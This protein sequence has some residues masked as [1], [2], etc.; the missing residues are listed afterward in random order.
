MSIKTISAAQQKRAVQCFPFFSSIAMLVPVLIPIWIAASIFV[1]AAV[2]SH[3]NP[4]VYEYTRH[5]GYRFYS[6]VGALVVI[7]NFSSHLASMAGGAIR[8]ALILWALGV[9]IVVPLGVRDVVRAAREPWRDM[10]FETD[11]N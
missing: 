10:Q 3:P 1:Y 9:L 2:V 4:R 7:L 8:L 11:E 5:T 6:V